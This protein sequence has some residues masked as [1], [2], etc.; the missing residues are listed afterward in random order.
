MSN[1]LTIDQQFELLPDP[2]R[3]SPHEYI[4]AYH[5]ACRQQKL[6]KTLRQHRELSDAVVEACKYERKSLPD[7]LKERLDDW[8]RYFRID[9]DLDE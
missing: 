1:K 8:F 9:E 4:L 5:L 7:R 2:K 6:I 3:D